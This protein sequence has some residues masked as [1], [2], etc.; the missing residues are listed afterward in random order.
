MKDLHR[1]RC[2][3]K[4][5]EPTEFKKRGWR[6]WWIRVLNR[7]RFWLECK[8]VY[9]V[10]R[11]TAQ[12]I[13]ET[14]VDVKSVLREFE[15]DL[16]TEQEHFT[17]PRP[18]MGLSSTGSAEGHLRE[19]EKHK[20]ALP[21]P[22]EQTAQ[23]LQR[24]GADHR[25]RRYA[26]SRNS[27]IMME[28]ELPQPEEIITHGETVTPFQSSRRSESERQPGRK[29]VINPI[30]FAGSSTTG[31]VRPIHPEYAEEDFTGFVG[32]DETVQYNPADDQDALRSE[33][34]RT[35]D[36]DTAADIEKHQ[37][38]VLSRE[39]AGTGSSDQSNR[40]PDDSGQGRPPFADDAGEEHQREE[41]RSR[42][43]ETASTGRATT[44]EFPQRSRTRADVPERQQDGPSA[45]SGSGSESGSGAPTTHGA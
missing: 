3:G 27:K 18:R 43:T 23:I 11:L 36:P 33:R 16:Q 17:Q 9:N 7:C 10:L 13:G 39:A 24:Y 19:L 38:S 22:R 21:N 31:R 32:D 6:G 4:Y 44:V 29:A 42:T 28:A 26:F 34:L 14:L 45:E 30:P 1:I 37:R 2:Y 40:G 15:S 35:I 8:V 20:N 12:A 41:S 25:S 5:Y